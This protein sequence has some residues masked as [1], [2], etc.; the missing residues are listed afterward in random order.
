MRKHRENNKGSEG[1]S[2][3]QLRVGEEL[4][5]MIAETLQRE[6]F[7][8]PALMDHAH[9]VTVTEVRPSPDLKNATVFVMTLGG[10]HM[11]AILP[12]LNE[13][14]TI[15]QKHIGAHLR[16]KFTPKVKFVA[17]NS[18]ENA[19]KIDMLLRNL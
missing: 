16:L 8:D 10:Q 18:F 5:H 11:D 3:R 6:H 14:A 1:P 7:H 19:E 15:F 9:I 2:Q 13:S 12:A 17:D 4:R